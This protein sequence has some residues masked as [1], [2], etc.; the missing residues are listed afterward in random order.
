M[1]ETTQYSGCMM[2]LPMETNGSYQAI[3]ISSGRSSSIIHTS[4]VWLEL[5][6]LVPSHHVHTSS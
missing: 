5:A 3:G 4:S 1:P 6:A 2:A